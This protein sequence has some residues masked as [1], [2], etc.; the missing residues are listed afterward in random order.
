MHLGAVLA[1]R[2]DLFGRPELQLREQ[3]VVL[4][5]ERS[6]PEFAVDDAG[7]IHLVG[8][9]VVAQITTAHEPAL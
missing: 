9:V 5:S 1:R 6:E 3:C 7:G 4:V 2:A 8:M